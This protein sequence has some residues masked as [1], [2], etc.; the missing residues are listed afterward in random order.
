[1]TVGSASQKQDTE[2]HKD[3]SRGFQLRRTRAPVRFDLTLLIKHDTDRR[4]IK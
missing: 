3:D 1:M 4:R 2:K